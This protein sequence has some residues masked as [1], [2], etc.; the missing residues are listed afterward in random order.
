LVLAG[1]RAWLQFERFQ[2]EFIWARFGWFRFVWLQLRHQCRYYRFERLE[3]R[4]LAVLARAAASL[5]VR[6]Q[7][8]LDDH[9]QLEH[10]WYRSHEHDRYQQ[11]G[12]KRQQHRSVRHRHGHRWHDHRFGHEC[13]Q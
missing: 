12:H 6:F 10:R 9:Y 2:F 13:D 4:G 11:D 1:R 7:H 8:Q 3:R 5:A